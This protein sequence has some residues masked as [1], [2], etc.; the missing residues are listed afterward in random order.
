MFA[1][2]AAEDAYPEDD[3]PLFVEEE[4]ITV[5]GT[6]ERSQQMAVIDRAAIERH[7]AADLASLLQEA[8]D[9]GVTRYGGYGNQAS[10]NLRGFD[11]ERIAF[12]VD[13]VPVNSATDGEFDINQIGLNE[14][15][16]I[17]VIYGGS[18]SKYNVSGALGG[19][20]NI[21][22]V[23]KQ[24][25]GLRVT[26]G[27]S[28]TS[29]MPGTY[30]S[31]NGKTSGP[32]WE[33]LADTQN[34]TFS[35]AW[36]GRVSVSANAFFNRAGNHFLFID[37]LDYIRRKDNNEIWDAGASLSLAG[38]TQGLTRL[39]STT[40]LYY[41]DKNIPTSGFSSNF[42]KQGDSSFRQNLMLDMPRA[43]HDSLAAEASLTWY[44]NKRTY[45][46]ASGA[47]SRHDQQSV[48]AINRWTWFG[49][50]RLTLRSGFDYR[51]FYLD[52]TDMGI[53]SR[54][55]GGLYLTAEYT[56]HK[57]LLFIPSVKFVTD[58]NS[59]VPIPKLGFAWSP[60][61]FF[62]LKNNYYRSFKFPDFEDLFWTGGGFSGNP[63]LKPE[64]GWGGDIGVV[65]RVKELMRLES[66]FFTQ[67]TAD[68]IHWAADASGSWQPRN[69]GEAVFF[70][71]DSRLRFEIP[72]PIGPVRKI[73]PSLSYQYMLS[74]LLSYGYTWASGKRIPYMPVHAVG[75]SLDIPWS[76]GSLLISGHYESLRYSDT[77]NIGEL[78]PQFLLNAA[79]NQRFGK[80]LSAYGSLRNILNKS[81]ESYADYPMP[82]TTFTLGMRVLFADDD[83]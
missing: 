82:G 59:L 74:Y 39:L 58:S 72:V 28:N 53:R 32:N 78:P 13:G 31:R 46:P 34:T 14:I 25:R 55:D 18:D 22:T 45:E 83:I 24:R 37:Y 47:S 26:A 12:L 70:G 52:S 71:S 80:Y 43:F 51:F 16:K 76:T 33:D 15:E 2:D 73:I 63:D 5:V 41:G 77:A 38:E 68:S 8:L 49:G 4:G 54:G 7:N 35:A 75:G 19:V 21:V 50:G 64:D 42:G 66:T 20:I 36:G 65:L 60:A 81:Y 79:V 69:V 3:G 27:F 11:S 10:V 57:A 61:D 30:R 9:L 40:T 23:K 6:E 1:Q 29:A 56:P 17:E 62:T 48:S 67:W 44:L